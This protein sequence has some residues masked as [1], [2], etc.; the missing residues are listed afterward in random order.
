METDVV[1]SSDSHVFEPPDLWTSRIDAEFKERAPHIRHESGVDN[2]YVGGEY[3]AGIGLILGAGTRFEAP[4]K[5]SYEGRLEDVHLGGYDPDEHVRD[6]KLDGV[7]A[8]VLYPSQGLFLFKVKDSQLLSAIFRAYNNWLAEFCATSP[9]HLKGI[10]MVNVDDVKDGVRELERTA[11]MGLVGAM[12]TEYPPE[13]RRY[14]SPEYERLWAAAQDLNIPLSLHTATRREGRSRGAGATPLRIAS[15]RA[16]KVFLPS[17]SLCDMIFSGVF[18]RYPGLKVAIVEFELAWAAHL[19][20]TMDYTYAERHEEATHRFKG[21]LKPSDFFHRHVYLS[22]QEDQI[23]IRLRDVIG[24][25][26]LMWGSDYPHSEATFP[27]S[28]ETLDR[29]LD[30]VPRDER[31]RIVGGNVA[32]LYNFDLEKISQD[33]D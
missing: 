12:I 29:I 8:E 28:R 10:A 11:Q 27:R 20:G 33:P 30:G 6:M 15:G 3:V 2:I 5:I 16:N 24:V 17:T 18:E 32:R 26:S 14:D 4:E 22:F 13:E 9:H 1:I 19:L 25:D 21:D 23:G 31:A 7:S